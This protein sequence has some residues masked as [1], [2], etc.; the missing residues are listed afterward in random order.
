M[1]NN[2]RPPR[3]D[4]WTLGVLPRLMLAWTNGVDEFGG[5]FSHRTIGYSLLLTATYH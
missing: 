1:D 5:A 4:Q 2:L 3:S